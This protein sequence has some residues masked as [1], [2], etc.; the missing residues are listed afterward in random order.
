MT[1][2][3]YIFISPKEL[4]IQNFVIKLVEFYLHFM[5]NVIFKNTELL[6]RMNL[7]TTEHATWWA[8]GEQPSSTFTL[9]TMQHNHV[10]I[11]QFRGQA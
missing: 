4:L 5:Q 7:Q 1:A 6:L 3:V 2:S 10:S 11:L 8:N 9:T